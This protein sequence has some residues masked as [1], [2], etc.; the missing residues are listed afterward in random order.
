MKK[1][2]HIPVPVEMQELAKD[3][4]GYPVPNIVL[5]DKNGR[6]HFQV[7]DHVKVAECIDNRLCAIC[8]KSLGDDIWFV[9]GPLSAFHP[10]GAY[11]DPPVHHNC[12]YYALQV[13]PWLASMHYKKRIDASTITELNFQGITAIDPTVMPERPPF[14]VCVKVKDFE[15]LPTRHMRTIKPYLAIE[16]WHHG[17][18]IAPSQAQALANRYYNGL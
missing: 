18:P 17:N 3:G 10:H 9:G 8:G 1:F 12:G 15:I 14:F 2:I 13:C 11:I 5:V 16:Y 6:P 7:N 4:R